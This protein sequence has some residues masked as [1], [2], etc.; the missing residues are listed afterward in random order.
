MGV[1]ETYSN[2]WPVKLKVGFIRKFRNQ[3][4]LNHAS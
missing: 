4:I 3:K 1:I 2:Y